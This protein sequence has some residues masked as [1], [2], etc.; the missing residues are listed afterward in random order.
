MRDEIGCDGGQDAHFKGTGKP[1]FLL[2]DGLPELL[3][4]YQHLPSLLYHL[5]ADGR[6]HDGL[7]LAVE[8][9]HTEF[10]FQF[11]YHRTEGGLCHSAV[12]GRLCEVSEPVD[13]HDVFKLL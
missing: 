3:C 7:P 13:C 1:L 2:L 9:F 11:L 4:P 6:G 10:V 12:V 8:D 5:P